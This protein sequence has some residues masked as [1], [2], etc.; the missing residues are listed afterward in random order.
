MTPAYYIKTYGC[1]MNAYDSGRMEDIF[2]AKGFTQASDIAAADVVVLNTC[3]IREKASEKLYSEI[4]RIRAN[5]KKNGET[6]QQMTIVTGC[7]AQAEGEEIIRRAPAVDV[8]LGPQAFQEL[9]QVL[10]TMLEK[11]QPRS[12]VIRDFLAEE[13]FDQLPEP[14]RFT[15]ISAFLTIQEGCDKFCSFCVV[16]YTR[17]AEY[18]RPPQDLVKEAKQLVANGAREL[19][20]LGQ[21]V[22]AYRATGPHGK[23]WGLAQLI[24]EIAA[25]DGVWRI[26]YTTSH[27]RDMDDDLINAHAHIPQLMPYL[28]LPVQSGSDA[29]LAAMNRK[30]SANDY[31][32]IITKLRDACPDI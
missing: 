11:G 13:K 18:S 25:L 12:R 8:V 28:H 16:P 19:T 31:R 24:A 26:R 29:I 6:E 4:G 30:H 3:H 27:P 2:L 1:Q 14:S 17:G 22:N 32:R 23:Q 21:N 9:A 15:G 10:D 5:R 7:V 20:L